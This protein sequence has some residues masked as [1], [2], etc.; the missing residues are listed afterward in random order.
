VVEAIRPH[1]TL[2]LDVHLMIS[3]P[4]RYLADFAQAGADYIGVHVEAC[5]HLHRTLARIAELGKRPVVTLN[6]H[7]PLV[8]IEHVLDMVDM[9]LIM[10]VNPGFGGQGFIPGAVDKIAALRS[11]L[12]QRGLDALIEVDGGINQRTIGACAA[13]GAQVFVAGSAVFGHDQGLRK[14]MELLRLGARQ[15]LVVS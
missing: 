3:D 13:A 7:T 6:P 10:S 14:A 9:V 2:P 4:D 8:S 12:H 15:A 1:T 5:H 11:L